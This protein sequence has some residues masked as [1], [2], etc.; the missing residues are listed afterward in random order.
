[1]PPVSF[2]AD[3][4]K[5]AAYSTNRHGSVFPTTLL[6]GVSMNRFRQI[7][8]LGKLASTPLPSAVLA[9]SNFLFYFHSN[10]NWIENHV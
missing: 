10:P 3:A 4:R 8:F 2:R 5:N 9:P 1:M 7:D 6:E